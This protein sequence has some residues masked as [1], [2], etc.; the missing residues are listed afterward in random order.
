MNRMIPLAEPYDP[1]T[2]RL[3]EAYPRR[4]GYL[5]SLF[6][7]FALSPRFLKKGVANL[8][9]RG[10]PLAMR[11]REIV[12]LRVTANNG[13]EYEWGV[14]VAAFAAHVGLDRR[15]VSATR[16]A[17]QPD[18]LWT[19][20]EGLLIRAVDGLCHDGRL[21]EETRSAFEATFTQ[22]EQLEILALA[23]N[24][25]TVSFV[26]NVARLPPESFAARFADY[27]AA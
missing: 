14:H 4:D 9:D 25:H 1:E 11:E 15:A 23:G 27:D 19:A 26:A 17:V 24:Y 22:A 21:N 5:L 18:D 16:A 13:C 10:S 3:L 12:I 6:R 8:L 20:R 7:V 2:T